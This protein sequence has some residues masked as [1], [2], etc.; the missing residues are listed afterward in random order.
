MAVDF[1]RVLA[2]AIDAALEDA[3]PAVEQPPRRR[4]SGVQAVAA[5]AAIAVIARAAV[6]KARL[7][8][9][10]NVLKL[11]DGVRDRFA[12]WVDAEPDDDE[13][14]DD[15]EYDVD[16]RMDDDYDDDDPDDDDDEPDD[17]EPGGDD[18]GDDYED[19]GELE[20]EYDDADESGD[21]AEDSPAPA[22]ELNGDGDPDPARRPPKPPRAQSRRKARS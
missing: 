20:D 12:D 5:G 19:D 13:D 10:V 8:Q 22:L 21:E 1:K 18:E 7:P 16:D 15:E 14:Y 2:S 11:A 6:S 9:P 17:D 4:V 3:R